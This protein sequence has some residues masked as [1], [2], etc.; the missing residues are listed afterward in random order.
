M[1]GRVSQAA[2]VLSAAELVRCHPALR[3]RRRLKRAPRAHR[4]PRASFAW[5]SPA[6]APGTRA[7]SRHSPSSP[8]SS[9]VP[10]S[11]NSRPVPW[12]SR[13]ERR[14]CSCARTV[15]PDECM[16][17]AP[18]ELH[19]RLVA[20]Y[21]GVMSRRNVHDVVRSEPERGSAL[22][23]DRDSTGEHDPDMAGLTPLPA[24]A[25]PEVRRPAPS[26]LMDDVSDGEVADVD[27]L[28]GEEWKLDRLVGLPQ[29]LRACLEHWGHDRWRAHGGSIG[30]EWSDPIALPAVRGDPPSGPSPSPSAWSRFA[31]AGPQH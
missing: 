14:E 9:W 1:R 25:R 3:R 19:E 5:G 15:R 16:K 12:A 13:R 8:F 17:S 24:D 11:S 6:P 30:A 29:V 4:R 23:Q 26:R 22:Q 20:D 18:L 27:D 28:R 2:S 10:R 7:K 31:T 21:P